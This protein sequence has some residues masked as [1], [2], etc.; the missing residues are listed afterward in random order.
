MSAN[1]LPKTPAISE[2]L[3]DAAAQLKTAGIESHRLDAELILTHTLRKGRTFLHAHSDEP[4]TSRQFEIADARLQLRLDR[5]PIAYIVGHKEFYGR[6]FRVTPATLIPRPE[7]ETIISIVSELLPKNVSLINRPLLQLVDVGTGTGCLGITAKLEAPEELAVSL[8]DISRHALKIA[9]LNARALQADV[10][11]L[12]SDLLGSYPLRA[13]IIVAN[14]PYVDPEWERS[15]ETNHEPDLALFAGD[16]GLQLINKLI[17]QTDSHLQPGGHLILEADP[18]QH[19]AI[20]S[21]A[22]N[23]GLTLREIRGFI[24]LL[25][26]R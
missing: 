4:L 9:Q 7:S 22:K 25:Q 10:Q 5:T 23:R 3:I 11:C 21:Y 1:L 6:T 16:H 14:L 12:Q 24:V 18:R 2:W 17:D 19:A 8:L 15:P 20:T 13:D 26:K